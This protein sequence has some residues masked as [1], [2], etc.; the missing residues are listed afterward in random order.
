MDGFGGIGGQVCGFL[1]NFE[2]IH[3]NG[4]LWRKL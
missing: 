2:L 4:E 3:V 1:L